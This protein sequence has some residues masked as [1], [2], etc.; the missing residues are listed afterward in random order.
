MRNLS[1]SGGA[2][3]I[4][5]RPAFV[6]AADYQY[7]RD[8]PANWADRLGKLVGM[9]VDTVTFY[10]PWRHH[11]IRRENGIEHD[12]DGR[13]KPS[14]NLGAFMDACSAAGLRM[15]AKPG[16]FVHS[17]LNCGGL[18]DFV[19]PTFDESIEVVRSWG[20]EP[21][22]WPYDYSKMPAPFHPP[23]DAMAREWLEAVG[24]FLSHYAFPRG[25]LIG[26]QLLDETIYCRSNNGPWA[27]GYEASSMAYYHGLLRQKYGTIAEYNRAHGTDYAY[28]GQAR[29][30]GFDAEAA[31]EGDALALVDWGEYQWRCRR[32]VYL[33]Y[34]EYLGID[35]PYITNYAPICP[36]IGETMPDTGEKRRLEAGETPPEYDRLHS[37]W[38]FANNRIDF[39]RGCYEYG[40]ISW[41]GVA[42]YEEDAFRRFV[43]TA[44]RARGINM[45]E[46]YGFGEHYDPRSAMPIVPFFQ[47]LLSVAAGATGYVAFVGVGGADYGTDLDDQSPPPYPSAAPIS[48]RGELT[49]MYHSTAL[50]NAWL[51]AEGDAVAAAE[52]VLDAAW[53]LVPEYSSISSWHPDGRKWKVAGRALPRCGADAWEPFQESARKAGYR[54]GL[55][56]IAALGDAELAAIP[57]AAC[58]SAFF[59]P[60]AA[61][62]ALVRYVEGG[63]KLILSGELPEFD[64]LL[65][66]CALLRD[67]VE[68]K[69]RGAPGL[70]WEPGNFFLDGDPAAALRAF[71][72]EPAL[73]ADPGIEAF[74]F[75]ASDGD[76]FLFFF[77]IGPADGEFRGELGWG[78]CGMRLEISGKGCGAVR[79]R[80]G[81][82][83]SYLVKTVNEIEGTTGRYAFEAG[84]VRI[85]G[86]GDARG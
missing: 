28:F 62:E 40:F 74:L 39:D 47:S 83:A 72:V 64:E 19:S 65:R 41:L 35:L 16:P 69:G 50:L 9:G 66:P 70:R 57:V 76:S 82:I 53:F 13:T 85:E 56:E 30:A 37:D 2:Y 77:N 68:G 38:W 1:Y 55:R 81:K 36:P 46:N 29:A 33:R 73:R 71:G 17:E 45:E 25:S 23:F 60:R 61:Q 10:V 12:F 27:M 58:M 22:E 31:A 49:P 32:D 67:F 20:D 42:A 8:S 7:Y 78:G 6:K 80:D 4:D 48:H 84:G 63:G 24:R 14:R 51:A 5:G 75:K 34:K 15:I 3:V 26:I 21:F 59:M 79:I 18:P 86:R 11:A 54:C 43:N 44:T 52:P